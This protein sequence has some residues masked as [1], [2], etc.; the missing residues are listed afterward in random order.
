MTSDLY[1]KNKI[2]FPKKN[3]SGT[4]ESHTFHSTLNRLPHQLGFPL[5]DYLDRLDN[6]VNFGKCHGLPS[7]P[8]LFV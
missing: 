1:L 2:K 5:L 3:Q 4:V 7:K 6:G 8:N